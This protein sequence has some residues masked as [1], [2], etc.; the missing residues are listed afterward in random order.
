MLL[1]V[2]YVGTM[3]QVTRTFDHAI[4]AEFNLFHDEAAREGTLDLLIA[5]RGAARA[6]QAQGAFYV[7]DTAAGERILNGAGL[8]GSPQGW[9]DLPFPHAPGA[10]A[11]H[12]H[13]LRAFAGSLPDGGYL[14]V[15]RDTHARTEIREILVGNF[16]VCLLATVGL[17]LGSGF[18]AARSIRRRIDG[19]NTVLREVA[20]GA[21]TRRVPVGTSGDELDELASRLNTTLERLRRTMEQLRQISNDLAHDLRTPLSRLHQGLER[22]RSRASSPAEYQAAIDRAMAEA[23]ELLRIFSAL[24]RIAQLE[25]GERRAS[26]EPL[27]LS[28]LLEDLADTYRL[29]AE[30]GG[31]T[32][33]ATITPAARVR[34]DRQLLVQLAVNLIE[35]ALAH[36]RSPAGIEVRLECGTG[37][38][39]IEV[40]DHGSGI[41][42][43]A[44][45]EVFKRF[46]RLD[47]SRGT[48]GSGLGLS[49]VAAIADLHGASI[50]LHDNAP[51][52]LARVRLPPE[53]RRA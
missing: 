29:V 6:E 47:P 17:A 26:F 31:Q 39:I 52:L 35:N 48:P 7:L 11:Q 49:L 25:A 24:L 23:D 4:T 19:I 5:L 53:P 28:A 1:A 10:D 15:A 3:R 12:E 37:C 32:L 40:G 38:A 45:A 8:N 13:R 16:G 22:V 30:D 9:L 21:I 20:D 14:L 34:G 36:G 44:R 33:T 41:P 51:G 2:V 46:F 43:A 50:E 18:L 27:D 42:E